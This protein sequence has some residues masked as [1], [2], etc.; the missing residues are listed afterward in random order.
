MHT[1]HVQEQAQEHSAKTKKS[2]RLAAMNLLARREHSDK[3]LKQK[4]ML[5]NFS[6]QDADQAL[7]TL[8]Q[9][10]LQSNR[11]FTENYIRYRAQ[12]GFGPI[13]IQHELKQKGVDHTLIQE[14]MTAWDQQWPDIMQQAAYKYTSN[15]QLLPCADKLKLHRFLQQRGFPHD[16]IHAYT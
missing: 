2:A 9:D 6:A 11:R 16:L 7:T 4:L 3:E 5:R 10:G 12:K 13:K 14:L 1:E 8:Q 15:Y